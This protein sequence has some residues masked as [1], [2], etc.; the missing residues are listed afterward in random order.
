MIVKHGLVTENDS[1]LSVEIVFVKLAEPLVFF[2]TKALKVDKSAVFLMAVLFI[3]AAI[4]N[5]SR[6]TAELEGVLEV[7]LFVA[8]V[9]T[10]HGSIFASRFVI[11]AGK[12]YGNGTAA[13]VGRIGEKEF[14]ELI[15]RTH[16]GGEVTYHTDKVRL[17]FDVRE[18]LIHFLFHLMYVSYKENVYVIFFFLTVE[19]HRLTFAFFTLKAV[20]SEFESDKL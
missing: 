10:E 6:K 20:V 18:C 9:I 7:T 17:F 13:E 2:V 11:T 16:F 12:G 3:L 5:Q 19:G 1:V 8:D 14:G 15:L 4:D